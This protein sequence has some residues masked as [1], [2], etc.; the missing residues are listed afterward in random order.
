MK[1]L[2]L[3]KIVFILVILACLFGILYFLFNKNDLEYQGFNLQTREENVKEI[4]KVY[5]DNFKTIGKNESAIIIEHEKK[6]DGVDVRRDYYVYSEDGKN[7]IKIKYYEGIDDDNYPNLRQEIYIDLSKKIDSTDNL[8]NEVTVINTDEWTSEV[9]DGYEFKTPIEKITE[10]LN[11]RYDFENADK[12]IALNLENEVDVIKM[13]NLNL[14]TYGWKYEIKE[15]NIYEYLAFGMSNEERNL[16]FNFE[17]YEDNKLTER[18]EMQVSKQK[19]NID[20]V[21]IPEL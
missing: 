14:R 2:N 16:N 8:Y 13:E 3:A 19:G 15:N 1:N 10:V 18:I 21:T 4:S 7:L 17:I 6:P 9:I 11:K 5:K 20:D 12:E